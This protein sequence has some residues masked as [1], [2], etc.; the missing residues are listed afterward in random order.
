MKRQ[1]G[2]KVS[3]IIVINEKFS[4]S[5]EYDETLKNKKDCIFQTSL[6]INGVIK[7]TG[8]GYSAKI[9]KIQAAFKFCSSIE[10]YST[11]NL[12]KSMNRMKLKS[13][14]TSGITPKSQS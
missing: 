12:D 3:P 5:A 4:T 13:S 14:N 11:D 1:D 10:N 9:S 8:L 7:A 6:K 2:T